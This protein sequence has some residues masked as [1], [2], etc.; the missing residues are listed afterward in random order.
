MPQSFIK[1]VLWIKGRN[2]EYDELNLKIGKPDKSSTLINRF[3]FYDSGFSSY[4]YDKHLY[5]LFHST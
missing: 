4:T 2:D 5:F 1:A 3:L